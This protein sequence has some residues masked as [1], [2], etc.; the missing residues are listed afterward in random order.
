MHLAGNLSDLLLALWCG[1][2]DCAPT[3]NVDTWDW[4]VLRDEDGWIAHGKAVEVA[5]PYLP[6]SF[7]RKP[8]NIAEKMNTDYKTW[9]F[10]L[11]TFGLGPAL[12]YN[13]LPEPYW[14][15][16]CKLVRGFQIMSQ[17]SLTAEDLIGAFILLG[18]WVRE[19]E[20]LYYQL[21]EDHL[22]FVLPM[23]PP[24]QSSC[25]RDSSEGPP[26]LLV[27]SGQ[28]NVLSEASCMV[29]TLLSIMPDLDEPRKHLSDT[30][31][32][33][34][35]GYALL[36]KRD[37]YAKLP[38][39]EEAQAMSDFLGPIH[40]LPCIK[41]WSRLLLP[42][43]QIARSAWR[44]RLRS[45]DKT[46]ISRNVKLSINGQ[47]RFAEVLYYMRLAVAD[48]DADDPDDEA[49]YHFINIA[50]IQMY[51]PPDDQLL[52]LSSQTVI[53]C[54]LLDEVS[55]VNV[56]KIISVIAMIPHKPRLPSGITEDRFFMLEKPGLDIANF[57]IPY[58]EN[59]ADD[60]EDDED[61]NLE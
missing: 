3:D 22:H 35:D 48:P 53:S 32:D 56:K 17:H 7:D 13:I 57:G 9:E 24:D 6:G 61:V 36:R 4:A 29:N 31:A 14:L 41:K 46:W 52:W 37:R 45:L 2:M 43:G 12:L 58:Y 47:T 55:I 60:A 1:T 49:G 34:G 19:F 54:T 50:V 11:Y 59:L 8:Q 30:A 20:T 21:R 40:P 44:E 42:N 25:D 28:W 27:P 51:S 38:V 26:N 23:Y 33:L 18:T 39:G 16:Y 15:N 10:H 5:G